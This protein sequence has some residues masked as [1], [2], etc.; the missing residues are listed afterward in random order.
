MGCVIG[1]LLTPRRIPSGHRNP[2]KSRESSHVIAPKEGERER[3]KG[4][5]NDQEEPNEEKNVND[6]DDNDA[7]TDDAVLTLPY[8]AKLI[9]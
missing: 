6:E 3:T 4:G 7:E 9:D 5:A 2:I 8:V 1:N